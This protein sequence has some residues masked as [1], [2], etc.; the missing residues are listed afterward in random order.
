MASESGVIGWGLVGAG[1]HAGNRVA[2]AILAAPNARLVGVVGRQVATA[3]A[4][5]ERFGSRAYPSLEAL[6]ADPAVQAIYLVTPN[7]QH[8]PATIQAAAAD[9]HV[10]TEKPMALSPAECRAMVE[11]CRAAGVKLGVGF[12]LRQH[13]AHQQ[14]RQLL[15]EG[16]VGEPTFARVQW[17]INRRTVR[18]G[19]WGRP[20]QAGAGIMYGTG[21]HAIDL[22]R[23]VLGREVEAV[24]AWT[25]ATPAQPL[26]SRVLAL[27]RFSGGLE[28]ML[29]SARAFGVPDNDLVIHGPDGRLRT[30]DTVWEDLGGTLEVTSVSTPNASQRFSYPDA[31]SDLRLY[32][33]QVERF[34][35][36]I[37]GD[38]EPSATGLDGLA[39]AQVTA[40]IQRSSATG[41]TVQ[42][43]EVDPLAGS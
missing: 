8:A 35:R 31:A 12:H 11:A 28:V 30:Q 33:D 15:A 4:F 29:T 26:D 17:A 14:V 7:D 1:R 34:G 18:E 20:E 5:A 3:E 36:A 21:V 19:W 38:G 16:A 41:R 27:L 6:L 42:I 22:L 32:A 13:P 2:P 23:F 25:D 10:L 9:R 24:A 43:A 37:L 40:A 39:A